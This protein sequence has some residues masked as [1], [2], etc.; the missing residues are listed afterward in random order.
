[1]EDQAGNKKPCDPLSYLHRNRKYYLLKFVFQI[2]HKEFQNEIQMTFDVFI[3]GP[4]IKMNIYINKQLPH[5]AS[6]GCSPDSTA[7]AGETRSLQYT[8]L[9][10][11]ATKSFTLGLQYLEGKYCY[12]KLIFL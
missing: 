5:G 6:A 8:F 7:V 2:R 9:P 10:A 3:F 4:E 1:M 11:G 12:F